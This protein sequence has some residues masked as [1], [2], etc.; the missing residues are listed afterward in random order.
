M[1]RKFD[2]LGVQ[3]DVLNLDLADTQVQDWVARRKKVYVCVAP[4]STVVQCREDEEYRKVVNGAQMVTPDGMPLVWLGRLQGNK[5]LARTYGPDLMLQICESGLRQGCRH[6]FYGA[7]PEVLERLESRLKNQFPN[8]NIVGSFCPP[9]TKGCQD[10]SAEVLKEI[11]RLQ[12]DI[13]WVGLGSPKQDFWMSRHRD[14]L[15]VPVMIGVGAAFD[16]LSG[17]KKQAPVWMQRAGLEWLFRF[18]CEPRRLWRRYLFGNTKFVYLIL[19]DF[20]KIAVPK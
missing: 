20:I 15:D 13:L 11:N 16:F 2:V 1:T 6:Y 14:K 5:D 12:P 3:V 4:V 8:I 10:E 18:L 19:R 7:I 9:F 17:S